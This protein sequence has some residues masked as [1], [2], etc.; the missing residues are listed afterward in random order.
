M[1]KKALEKRLARLQTKKQTL[2]TRAQESQ[3]VNE[4]RALNEQ[5]NDLNAEIEETQEELAAIAEEE[6]SADQTA[7][8]PVEA[9]TAVPAG[10]QVVNG[11]GSSSFQMNG[12]NDQN[13]READPT[14]SMEYRRAFMRY[15]QTGEMIPAN[16]LGEQ[17]AG[18]AIN[19]QDTGAAIPITVMR[20]VI[21][22]VRKRFGNLYSKV[23]KLN[24]PGGV[25]FPVG[26]LQAKFKWLAEGTVSP[27]QKT[28]ALA[29]VSFKYNAAEIRIAQTFLSSILTLEAFEM[30]ISRVIAVA[31]LEAMDQ[32]I[33]NGTGEGMP[34]GI[35]KDPAVTNVV[36]MTAAD[37]SSWTAWRKKFFA[38][39]PLGYRAGEFIFPLATVD[40]Y[41]ETM[42][43]SNNN[44]IFRQATGLEVN[45]G[46]AAE[47]NGRF[48][49]REI[50][51]VEPEIIP[52]FDT[53]SDG[54]VIGVYWQPEMYAINENWGFSMMRYFDQESNEWVDKALTVV[55]GKILNPK[56]YWLIKKKA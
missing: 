49:G 39:L 24:I 7:N 50:S 38:K 11:Q 41:L 6:R 37:F 3:D 21:N 22:T 54:D 20:E 26:A 30:E 32:A 18:N 47:P 13:Q 1:R 36:E 40:A 19:T 16:L 53:A 45:D 9:R 55:D 23:R 29:K 48:F 8:N 44:P 46:D 12:T 34:L 25:D 17:R 52:D 42:A 28:D 10:A 35:L 27:R 5:I 31:Y 56:G 4:V 14:E 43:D 15:V 33:V 51:L 2:A